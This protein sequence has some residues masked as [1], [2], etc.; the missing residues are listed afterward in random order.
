MQLSAVLQWTMWFRSKREADVSPES[1]NELLTSIRP[2]PDALEHAR[3]NLEGWLKPPALGK[4]PARSIFDAGA[5]KGT[6]G[7]HNAALREVEL[8]ATA[9]INALDELRPLLHTHDMF[10]YSD[11]FGP[12]QSDEKE[13]PWVRA[14]L[15]GIL[16]S[17]I[18][19]KRKGTRGKRS[20]EIQFGA[21][22]CEIF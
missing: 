2:R 18:D 4:S 13:R 12:V 15:D 7:P 6:S 19:A 16:S 1:I 17:A 5:H 10:W 22:V 9:L 3:Q 14:A 8:K 20:G 21:L 11:H